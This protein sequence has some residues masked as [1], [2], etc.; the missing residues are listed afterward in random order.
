MKEQSW[1]RQRA[2]QIVAQLPEDA[3]DAVAILRAAERF[4]AEFISTSDQGAAWA[5]R[6]GHH[7]RRA[8]H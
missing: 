7:G 3:E 5:A 4:V 6:R 1:H 8:Y 2:I